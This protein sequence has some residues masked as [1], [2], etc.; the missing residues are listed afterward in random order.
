MSVFESAQIVRH[1]AI[2]LAGAA[3]LSLTVV[4]G[5][6]IATNMPNLERPGQLA[7]PSAPIIRDGTPRVTPV[8]RTGAGLLGDGSGQAAVYRD[9]PVVT[10]DSIADPPI[11]TSAETR[12]ADR[13]GV[14][15]RVGL[16][17]TYVGARVAPVHT[18]T[19]SITVDTNALTVLSGFL[20]SEPVRE[21]LGVSTDPAGVTQMR[22]DVDTRRG[23]VTLMFSDPTLGD[24]ALELDRNPAPG[25]AGRPEAGVADSSAQPSDGE[26]PTPDARLVPAAGSDVV[27]T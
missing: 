27:T 9:R 4:S 1:T 6:Y 26:R 16:G 17:T 14:G 18:N 15:G 7:A 11:T 25:D 5:A 19:V 20:M 23:E 2:V 22:T 12:A 24:H 21:R 8:Q 10:P 13:A 3:S